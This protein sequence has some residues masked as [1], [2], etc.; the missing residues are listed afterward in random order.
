MFNKFNSV[1]KFV[2]SGKRVLE[3]INAIR[4]S[5]IVCSW[6]GCKKDL[7]YGRVHTKDI[8]YLKQLAQDMEVNF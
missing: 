3:Y 5:S 1:S 4:D 6:L 7:Y 2:V 8:P